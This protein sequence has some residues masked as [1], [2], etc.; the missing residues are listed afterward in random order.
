MQILDYE[1]VGVL[2]WGGDDVRAVRADWL[3]DING[4]VHICQL[5]N[6]HVFRGFCDT[7]QDNRVIIGQ[8]HEL[9]A[10]IGERHL[11][12]LTPNFALAQLPELPDKHSIVADRVIILHDQE[13][14]QL[15]IIYERDVCVICDIFRHFHLQNIL[16]ISDHLYS[17]GWFNSLLYYFLAF[18]FKC[19]L[20]R[21]LVVL[22]PPLFLNSNSVL[23]NALTVFVLIGKGD[24]FAADLRR[25]LI[26]KDVSLTFCGA[27]K[28]LRV[29]VLGY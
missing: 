16:I 18:I 28:D 17:F 2:V 15:D 23:S 21:C 12:D 24:I 6:D 3:K 4:S 8:S 19:I 20:E 29:A 25:P 27:D 10:T 22:D 7:E 9:L 13:D 1:Y 5:I 11:C 26:S 14:S